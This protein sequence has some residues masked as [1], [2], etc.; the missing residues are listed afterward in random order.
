MSSRFTTSEGVCVGSSG[1]LAPLVA[2]AAL[3]A[4]HDGP[5]KP[6]TGTFVVAIDGIPVDA[7]PFT[8]PPVAVIGP[9]GFQ[10][11]ITLSSVFQNMPHGT[12]PLTVDTV[13]TA[14]TSFGAPPFT[15]QI[16]VVGG[17]RDSLLVHYTAVTGSLT[18]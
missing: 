12:Y 2:L 16:E 14:T 10:A 18:L 13:R 3:L 17:S 5:T 6:K 9:N 11:S 7:I 8:R 1:R 4:C 15:R